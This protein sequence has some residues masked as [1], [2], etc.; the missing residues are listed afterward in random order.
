[1]EYFEE[2]KRRL[3]VFAIISDL[4]RSPSDRYEQYESREEVK[5]VLDTMK[6]DLESDKTYLRDNKNV[7]EILHRF[8]CTENKIQDTEGSEGSQ[9]PG[10]DVS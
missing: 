9:L 3:G 2:K 5:Q 6:R 10:K 8:H 1:M 7:K 4:D